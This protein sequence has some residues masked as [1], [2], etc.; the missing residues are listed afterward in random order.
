MITVALYNLKGGVGK[1][2]SCV[3]FAYLAA[4]D[5]FKTLLWDIDPQGSTTFYYKIKPKDAPGIKKLVSKDANLETAI[6]STNYENLEIIPADASA[7]SFDIML[8]EMKGNKNRLKSILRQFENE[9]DFVFIDCPPG[10]SMLSENIFQASDVVLMPI[11][12][13][14][15]S[16]RTYNMVKD[17]FKEKELDSTKLMCFFT[18]ADLRKNMHNEIMELLTKDKKFFQNY[19]PYLSDVEKMGIHRQPIEEFSPSSYAAKCYHELW[20]EIKEGVV[21]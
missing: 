14:T 3:N 2:A 7:K 17:Y 15:L 18:M 20:T 16:I 13:T 10:F 1:T 8:E 5:G 9:Y 21:A 4:K 11:I 12:P 6:M 19:I